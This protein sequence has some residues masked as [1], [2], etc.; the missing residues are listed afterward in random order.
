MGS[1]EVLKREEQK[2]SPWNTLVTKTINAAHFKKPEV[3]HFLRPRDYVTLLAV[4]RSGKLPLVR[5]YRPA[6]ERTTLELPGGLIDDKSE[7]PAA[8]AIRELFEET[9]FRVPNEPILLGCLDPDTGRLENR[10]WA[11]LAADLPDEAASG[12]RSEPGV[13]RLLMTKQELRG[14]IL[15]GEFN[16]ALHLGILAL[17]MVQGKFSF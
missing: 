7:A 3:Y 9:G 12:W 16:H 15:N 6:L 17:A 10:L 8:T 13:E 4:T 14:A 1:F 5:Q 2:L 11:Y